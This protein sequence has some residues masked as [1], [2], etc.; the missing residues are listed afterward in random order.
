MPRNGSGTYTLPQPAFVAGT[1]ISSSAVNSDLSDIATA[2]TGSLPRDGQA[3]MTGPLGV[4][5]GSL[6]SPGLQFNNENNTGFNRPNTGQLGV[7]IEGV[8][9]GYFDGDGWIG[10]TAAGMPVGGVADYA[11]STAPTGWLLCYGQ[12]VSRTT[13]ALLFAAIGTTYGSGDGATTFGLPDLRGRLI[14]GKDDMGGSAAS[15]LTTTYYGTDPTIVGNVGGAQSKTLVTANLP[16]YTPTGTVSVVDG[17]ISVLGGS[18]LRTVSGDFNNNGG[19]GGAFSAMSSFAPTLT[20]SQSGTTA[21]FSGVAQGGSATA[22]SAVNPG[23]IMN[24]IIYAGA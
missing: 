1:T 13:Y 2:L 4:S 10:S 3:G 19:G 20:A 21:S 18:N 7:V 14:Y 15:R 17:P 11:G 22:L 8:Q 12:N 16:A 9:V 24:K 6:I 5:D 23:I